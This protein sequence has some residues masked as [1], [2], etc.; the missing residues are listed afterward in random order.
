[1]K[2]VLDADIHAN[3]LWGLRTLSEEEAKKLEI[4]L[5]ETEILDLKGEIREKAMKAYHRLLKATDRP[6]YLIRSDE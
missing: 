3:I 6:I 2:T 5:F 4:E 1:M